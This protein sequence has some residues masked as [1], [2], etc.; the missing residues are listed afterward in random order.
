MASRIMGQSQ[1]CRLAARNLTFMLRHTPTNLMRRRRW[2]WLT[3]A[4]ICLAAATLAAWPRGPDDYAAIR[5]F[6]PEEEWAVLDRGP[7]LISVQVWW[8]DVDPRKVAV[9]LGIPPHP[10]PVFR[11]WGS[12]GYRFQLRSGRI[13][14]LVYGREGARH[15]C[16]LEIEYGPANWLQRTWTTIR[17]HLRL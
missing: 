9:A 13:A 17:K 8:F 11:G 3:L 5:R 4:A 10:D 7:G 15:T 2:L 6:H 1:G 16:D 14:T 12:N